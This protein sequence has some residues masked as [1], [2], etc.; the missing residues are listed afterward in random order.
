MS[1]LQ[2]MLICLFFLLNKVFSKKVIY[3]L[4]FINLFSW[5]IDISFLKINYRTSNTCDNV[6]AVSADLN[7]EFKKGKLSQF[8]S[9]RNRIVECWIKDEDRGKII[10]N[11]GALKNNK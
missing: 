7:I 8:Y 6:E 10:A 5:F 11:G 9:T 1:Y 3:I 2:P 4:I